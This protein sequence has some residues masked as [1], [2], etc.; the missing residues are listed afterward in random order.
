MASDAPYG[1]VTGHPFAYGVLYVI[2]GELSTDS[3]PGICGST[4]VAVVS[5][6]RRTCADV[7]S[8]GPG[9]RTQ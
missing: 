1:A 4:P 5:A 3:A 8:S 2:A 9:H 6:M 7:S